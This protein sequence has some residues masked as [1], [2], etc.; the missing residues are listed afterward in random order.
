M[1]ADALIRDAL[2]G[3]TRAAA[4]LMTLLEQESPQAVEAMREIYPKSGKLVIFLDSRHCH[5]P[6]SNIQL[7][8]R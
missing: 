8:Y 3:D 4:R 5:S 7:Y 1:N 6:L 2:M